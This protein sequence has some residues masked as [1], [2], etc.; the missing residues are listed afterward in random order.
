MFIAEVSSNH[1]SNLERALNFIDRAADIGCDGVKFQL[2]KIDELF[3]PE[4]LAASSAHGERRA[5]EL[6]LDFIPALSV[7]ARK[8]AIQFG[9]TPFYLEAVA[10]LDPYVDFLKIASY[11]LGW[12]EIV[13]LRALLPPPAPRCE[14]TSTFA[15][16]SA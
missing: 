4:V 1:S 16:P 14:P 9:C 10:E 8:R 13:N 7:R 3:A 6:P 11:E 5:W 2:F 12:V 15:T